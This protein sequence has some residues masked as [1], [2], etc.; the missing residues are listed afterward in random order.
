MDTSQ[1]RTYRWLMDI[2]KCTISL[3]I[4]EMQTKTTMRYH[5]HI[6]RMATIN[7]S[8]KNKCWRGCGRKQT[9]VHC[10][11]KCRLVQ[12]LWKAVQSYLKKLKMD[13]PFDPAIPLL[14]IHPKKPKALI[15][16][17]VSIPVLLQLFIMTKLWK[18]PK[19]PS[20][21]EQIKQHAYLHNGILLG[22]LKKGKFYYL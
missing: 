13:L 15:Q 6:S 1:K 12:P 9:L 7:T 5:S 20:I 10:W 19:F 4:R 2:Q 22:H 18:Q 21:D 16:K 8:T 3:I 17:N 11:W 14:R